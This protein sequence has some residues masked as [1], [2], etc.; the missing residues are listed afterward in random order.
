[1]KKIVKI[2]SIIVIVLS[3]SA[4]SQ[5][6][7]T[8]EEILSSEDRLDLS[9]ID[10]NTKYVFSSKPS[11]IKKIISE[12]N[13][14]ILN[15]ADEVSSDEVV[16]KFSLLLSSKNLTFEIIDIQTKSS[17]ENSFDQKNGFG[18]PSGLVKVKTCYSQ[19]CAREVLFALGGMMEN[20]DSFSVHR[21]LTNV[22]ICASKRLAK[23]YNSPHI[24]GN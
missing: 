4:C 1:M 7:K 15:F 22:T 19:A 2:I 16:T 3:F 17:L 6:D 12:I 13:S 5:D 14:E 21:R 9:G 23:E 10:I 24:E 11:T 20:G 8:S 18:C